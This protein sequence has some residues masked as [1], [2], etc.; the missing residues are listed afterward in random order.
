M[1]WQILCSDCDFQKHVSVEEKANIK[2]C[3]NCGS[4]NF[5]IFDDRTSEGAHCAGTINVPSDK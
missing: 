5:Q 4:K 2:E 3:P 1:A